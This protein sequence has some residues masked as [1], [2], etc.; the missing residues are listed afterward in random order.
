K[1]EELSN[2]S[3]YQTKGKTIVM[4]G[5]SQV[6]STS[7]PEQLMSDLDFNANSIKVASGGYTYTTRYNNGNLY[8]CL[9]LLIE[10]FETNYPTLIPDGNFIRM[11]GNDYWVS[12]SGENVLGSLEEAFSVPNIY[13]LDDTKIYNA[14]RRNLEYLKRKRP[15]AIMIVGN[16]YQQRMANRR[17]TANAVLEVCQRLSIQCFDSNKES[18]I[19]EY[20]EASTPTYTDNPDSSSPTKEYPYYNWVEPNGGVVTVGNKTENAIKRYGLYTYDGV[21]FNE[22]GEAKI[23]SYMKTVILNNYR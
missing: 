10:N 11:V 9:R 3:G 15:N 6:A 18:G 14:I 8:R 20:L 19:S 12:D 5:D 7:W 16:S 2:D 23:L 13:D 21:H 1:I 4:F 17:I 22:R